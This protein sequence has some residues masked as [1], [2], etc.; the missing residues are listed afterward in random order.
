M[1]DQARI[2]LAQQGDE[3]ALEELIRKHYQSIFAY[4]YKNTGQ[5]H[6]AMDLAQETFIRMAAALV[7]YRPKAAFKSWLFVIASNQL[8]NHYRTLSRRPLALTLTGEMP[9]GTPPAFE[10]ETR[11]DLQAA[12]AGL[13]PK[14][15]EALIL[16]F[17][18]GFTTRE[19]AKITGA[20]ESTVKARI[21]YG[22][23]KLKQ[24]LE[25]YDEED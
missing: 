9:G 14:Q 6:L 7:R 23:D 5:Y 1:E 22:L 24:K 8:K 10:A 18:H 15:R 13:P 17:Y 12:L 3:R 11:S 2:R 16:H 4:F 20:A 25:G 19:I 21:R